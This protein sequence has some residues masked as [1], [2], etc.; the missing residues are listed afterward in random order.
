LRIFA[1]PC[2]TLSFSL[3]LS[4]FLSLSPS[5]SLSLCIR[6]SVALIENA[7]ILSE[8][9]IINGTLTLHGK[10]C[11]DASNISLSLSLSLYIYIYIV[12]EGQIINGSLTLHGKKW[13][14]LVG[15]LKV[16]VSNA[17]EPYKRDDILQKRS[18][19]L[20]SLLIVAT[21]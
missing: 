20:R 11:G 15:S 8:G 3:S 12:S 9:Q 13:L 21:P 4:L 6:P 19:I 2:L 10:G 14:R 7:T 18:I 16:K 1:R 5:L 17:K